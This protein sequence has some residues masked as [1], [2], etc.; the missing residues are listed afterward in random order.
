MRRLLICAVLILSLAACG[1]GSYQGL[2]KPTYIAFADA[3]CKK[4][5][6]L[7]SA[8]GNQLNGIKNEQ[9]LASELRAKVIP[10]RR[11]ELAELR[12]LKPPRED[13]KQVDSVWNLIE[14]ETNT[15]DQT[16]QKDPATALRNNYEPYHDATQFAR[17]YGFQVCGP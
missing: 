3:I 11:Q 16:L 17:A 1:G 4:Y 10:L 15:V 12:K 5:A 7:R 9:Q 13:K 14:K 8:V 2:P 6:D